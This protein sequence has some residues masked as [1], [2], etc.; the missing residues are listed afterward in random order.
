MGLGRD[1]VTALAKE[2]AR[3][4]LVMDFDGV[5]SPIVADPATSRL[6]PGTGEVLK[7]LAARLG[8]VALVSGRPVS[9]LVERAGI[10][11]VT[12]VGSYGVETYAEGRVQVLPEVEEWLPV[13]DRA[14]ERLQESLGAL[15]GVHLEDKGVAIAVHWRQAPDRAVAAQ[16]VGDVVQDVV[17]E[18]GLHR[19]P[20]KFVEELRPPLSQDKGVVLRRLVADTAVSPVAYAGDDLGDLPAFDAVTALGGYPLVIIHGEETAPAVASASTISFA[21][22]EGFAVWLSALRDAVYT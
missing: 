7:D 9:F 21:G 1:V 5:L 16:L 8:L 12:L 15:P 19:E 10:E 18:T 22:V 6:L 3:A 14:R 2:P 11:G 13:V 20:G 4:G 17:S